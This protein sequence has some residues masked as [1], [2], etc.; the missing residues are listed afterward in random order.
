MKYSECNRYGI[1]KYIYID[2]ASMKLMI[3][4]IRLKRNCVSPAAG[5]EKNTVS[6]KR[7]Y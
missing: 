3:I 1:S 4:K 7:K 2:R 5:R 6:M